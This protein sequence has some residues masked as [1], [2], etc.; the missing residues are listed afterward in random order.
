MSNGA[1]V[2]VGVVMVAGIVG[3]LLPV[4]PGLLLIWAAGL[5]TTLKLVA[6]SGS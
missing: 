1:Q 6:G 3:I 4:L 5:I 2:L